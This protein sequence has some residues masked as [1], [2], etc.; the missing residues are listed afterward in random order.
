MAPPQVNILMFQS[1][2]E[3]LSFT[4]SLVLHGSVVLLRQTEFVHLKFYFCAAQIENFYTENLPLQAIKVSAMYDSECLHTHLF[5][6]YIH[7]DAFIGKQ[8]AIIMGRLTWES[9]PENKR[10]YKD[11]FNI[12][13]TRKKA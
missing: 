10:P 2:L 3:H 11:R 4:K 1:H 8:N 7:N 12:I 9:L 5:L 6:S 13:L